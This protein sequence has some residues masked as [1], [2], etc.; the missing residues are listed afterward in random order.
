VVFGLLQLNDPDP[1]LWLPAYFFSAYAA[2]CA[3]R[4]YFNPF[5]LMMLCPVYFFW[6]YSLF[7]GNISDWISQEQ[8]AKSLK[9]NMPFIE[10]AR[11]S[12]GLFICFLINSIYLFIGFSKSKLPNYNTSIFKRKENRQ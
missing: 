7:P 11:E 9:M 5:L 2:Y 10:E 1:H 8:T 12:L 3:A 6:A 4:N